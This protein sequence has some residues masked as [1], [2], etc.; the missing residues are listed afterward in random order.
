MGEGSITPFW[1]C[2]SLNDLL[3]S[4]AESEMIVTTE[5]ILVT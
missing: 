3:R 4:I 5:N 2:M 1:Q